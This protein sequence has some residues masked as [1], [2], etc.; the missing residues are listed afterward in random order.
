M[1]GAGAAGEGVSR[2]VTDATEST[3]PQH[4][5]A[6]ATE[7]ALAA[8]GLGKFYGSAV[9]RVR[10][11][12]RALCLPGEVERSGGHWALRGVDFALARGQSLGVIGRNGAGKSTLLRLLAGTARPT[13]G[14]VR[15]GSPPGCLLDLGVGFDLLESGRQN[16]LSMLALTCPGGRR[17]ALARLAEVAEF[18]GLGADLDRPVRAYS[19]GMRLRLAFATAIAHRPAV[20]VTDEVLVVGDGAFQRRCERWL[21]DFLGGGGTLVLCSHDLVQIRRL[22][23]AGIWIDGGQVRAAGP[24]AGVIGA[25]RES[26]ASGR[27]TA[28][29]V[30]VG[31][32]SVGF[33]FEVVSLALTD[34]DGREVSEIPAGGSF[35]AEIELAAEAGEP[36]VFVGITTADLTPVYG[37]ASD[38]DAARARN[39]GPG[40]WRFRLRFD[41]LALEA[42]T[43]RLRA[44]ALDETGTRLYDTVERRFDVTARGGMTAATGGAFSELR[45]RWIAE[46]AMAMPES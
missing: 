19:D 18:A 30:H 20:L 46:P 36:N 13:E 38:M 29:A 44:H 34:D 5:A 4:H 22:C 41:E 45:G 16:A 1:N 21:E 6:G 31:G 37:V 26:I 2:V 24:V 9:R 40:R 17:E 33:A 8:E 15:R 43:Y 23:A 10:P 25:Y 7:P 39:L 42:G 28:G 27:D 3:V 12:L 35:V 14:R 32:V 11:L